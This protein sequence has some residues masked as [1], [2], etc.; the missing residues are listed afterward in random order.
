MTAG[1][2]VAKN[3]RDQ[4]A[5]NTRG[6][7]VEEVRGPRGQYRRSS[8]M[9]TRDQV[10]KRSGHCIIKGQTFNTRD[11]IARSL[12]STVYK[13]KVFNQKAGQPLVAAV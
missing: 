10:T 6:Q 3:T 11:Q 5:K 1:C 2:Q 4:V 8:H 13:T 9:D 7:S 12:E